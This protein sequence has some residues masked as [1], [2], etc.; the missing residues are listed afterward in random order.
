MRSNLD[1]REV[2]LLRRILLEGGGILGSW[3]AT[4]PCHLVDLRDQV[5]VDPRAHDI[6]HHG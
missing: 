4:I 6:L 1:Q 3:I 2:S 5:T